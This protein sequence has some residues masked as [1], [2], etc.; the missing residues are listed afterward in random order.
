MIGNGFEHHPG[1]FYYP[2]IS[3]GGEEKNILKEES[4]FSVLTLI[5]SRVVH[6][7]DKSK[8][9]ASNVQYIDLAWPYTDSTG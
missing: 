4:G 9:L 6:S 2:H 7:F 5:I 3:F 8:V 1:H